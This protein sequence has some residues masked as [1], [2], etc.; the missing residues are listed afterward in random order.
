MSRLPRSTDNVV[1]IF[2]VMLERPR[3]AWYG[4]ELAKH[5]GI[6]SATIYAALTRL[7]RA[8]LLAASWETIDSADAGRPRRRLYT[9]TADGARAGTRA[10]K[11]Y[12]PRAWHKSPTGW[13]PGAEGRTT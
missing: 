5:T 13:L 9:L 3:K 1:A 4:L 8:G 10:V 12:K 7:E 11:E 2:A 6:G